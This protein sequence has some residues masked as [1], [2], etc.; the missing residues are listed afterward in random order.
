MRERAAKSQ[1]DGSSSSVEQPQIE[2]DP[3]QTPNA[4][5]VGVRD[6]VLAQLVRE[7]GDHGEAMDAAGAFELT[8]VCG[9]PGSIWGLAQ[10]AKLCLVRVWIWN[11]EVHPWVMGARCGTAWVAGVA[12]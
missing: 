9:P 5:G 8:Q 2:G 4:V 7:G 11:R 3:R 1:V 10:S 12:E 6:D